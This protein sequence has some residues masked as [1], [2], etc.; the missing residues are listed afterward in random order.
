MYKSIIR[1]QLYKFDPKHVHEWVCRLLKVVSKIPFALSVM[2]FFYAKNDPRLERKVFGL[3]FK[4]P[5]GLAAGFDK[6]ANLID[7]MDALGFGFVEI[8]TITLVV[9]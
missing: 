8:G 7:E 2:K 4:N 3:V 5:V 6:T 1:K 9:G